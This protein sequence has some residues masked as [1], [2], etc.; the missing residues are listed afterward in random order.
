MA[1]PHYDFHV[2][3]CNNQRDPN[4]DR[5]CCQ[6]KGAEQLIEYMKIVV[7]KSAIKNIRINKAGCL[8]E[9]ER[10]VSVVVYPEGRWYRI[11]ST[12]DV[13]RIVQSCFSSDA[14]VSDLLMK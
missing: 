12:E 11:R 6:R 14:S 5:G 4:A 10:G 8:N 9:C 1:I 2:F 7:K 13:D 3:I